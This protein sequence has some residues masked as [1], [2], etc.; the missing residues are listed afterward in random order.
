MNTPSTPSDHPLL[1]ETRVVQDALRR[2]D[3][4]AGRLRKPIP[5]PGGGTDGEAGGGFAGQ[6]TAVEVF[7]V[8]WR[9]E[10]LRRAWAGPPS[11][12][13]LFADA[14]HAH[15]SRPPCFSRPDLTECSAGRLRMSEVYAPISNTV[16]SCGSTAN[17]HFTYPNISSRS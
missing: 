1:C 11:G 13:H 5:Q 17:S 3:G 9:A 2:A 12:V 14:H 4:I 7:S 8:G 16:H 15:A 10:A 6:E